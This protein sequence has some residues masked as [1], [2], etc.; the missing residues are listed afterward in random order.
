MKNSEDYAYAVGRVRALETGLIS[1]EIFR[2]AVF[3]SLTEA[4]N[5]L[6]ESAGEEGIKKIR[7]SHD[8]E[9]FLK[10]RALRSQAIVMQLLG[11]YELS[12]ALFGL[13][14]NLEAVKAK[15]EES[16]LEFLRGLFRH[17]EKLKELSD[18]LR[19]SLQE[20]TERFFQTD[21]G[22]VARPV[23]EAKQE[24]AENSW[25]FFEKLKDGFMA[26][27]RTSAKYITF[28]PEP[29]ISYYFAKANENRLLR[30]VILGKLN[31]VP[32]DMLLA[33]I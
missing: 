16:E 10:E 8:L 2:S 3:G 21:Y 20:K 14:E 1:P 18:A 30:W 24:Q 29:I 25:I 11:D 15:V 7:N 33:L 9:R 17:T 28:G 12:G 5:I 4:L 19:L 23:S 6:S 31:Q 27:F 26:D 32:P 22:S 13:S